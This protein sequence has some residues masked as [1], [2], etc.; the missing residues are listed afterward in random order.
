ML[1]KGI[2]MENKKKLN[3]MRYWL[4]GTFIIFFTAITLYI[5]VVLGTG[6]M[7][8]QFPDYWLAI[9]VIAILCMVTNSLYKV[10]L[11]RNA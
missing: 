11:G 8:F 5:G 4:F 9:G 7:V 1:Q 3:L 2:A 10:Y 6:L